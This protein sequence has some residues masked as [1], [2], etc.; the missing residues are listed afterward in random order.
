MN[1]LLSLIITLFVCNL[2]QGSLFQTD[3]SFVFDEMV[4]ENQT[5]AVFEARISGIVRSVT[6]GEPLQGATVYIQEL[7]RGVTTGDDGYFELLLPAGEYT[8]QVQYLGMETI[9]REIVVSAEEIRLEFEMEEQDMDLGEIIVEGV[10]FGDHIRGAVTGVEVVTISDLTPLP[11]FMGEIDV[12]QSLVAL[13]GVQTVG[14][15]A[16]GFNVRGG[17]EDQNLVLM[18]GAP[19]FNSSHVL[20]LFSVFNPDVTD[21]FALYKGHMPERFGGRL[22]SVLDVSMR[23]G[24]MQE[25]KVHGGLGLYSGRAMIEGPIIRNRLSFLMA[26]RGAASGII[27]QV[28]GKERD[29]MR[30]SLPQDVYNSSARFYDTNLNL[31]YRVNN[32]N[33]I[34]LSYYGSHDFFRFSD[35]FG[36]SWGNRIANLKWRSALSDHL[37]SDFSVVKNQ[38]N[39]SYFTPIGPDAFDLQTGIGYLRLQEELLYTGFQNLTINGGF[40]WTQ[41]SSNDESITPYHNQSVIATEK[42]PKD[43]GRELALY[44]GNELELG[45]H[46]LLLLGVRYSQFDHIGPGTLFE[47]DQNTSR[48]ASSITDSTLFASGDKMASYQ[49]FE[50]RISARISLSTNSSIKISY[51]RTRQ[52]IHQISN[53]VSPT[54][55]DIWQVS[56]SHLPP[57]KSHNY[58][59]GYFQNFK[60]G[61]WEISIDF[62]YRDVEDLVEYIDFAE[63]FL[64]PHIETDL[65]SARGKA[66]GSE[67]NI[68]KNSGKWTGWLSYTLGRTFVKADGL[69]AEESINRGEWFPSNYDQPHNV[70]LTGVRSLGENSAFSFNFTWRTGR[71]IT[72]I[73]SGYLDN[74]TT[75]PVFTDRNSERIPDYIRLDL[76]FL[77]ADNIWAYRTPDPNRRISDSAN[78]TFYNILGRKNA[79]SVFYQRKPGAAVPSPYRL[80]VLG[81][82]IPSFTYN[83]NF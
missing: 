48:T 76:S 39:S 53:S 25:F 63:L 67:I 57:Q 18:D 41:Y 24:S 78:I 27:F 56:T 6:S 34:S 59:I 1:L 9:T 81:A 8:L 54:P 50:P 64:N 68:R 13:P 73:R 15:G 75:V 62:Y 69:F 12:V 5:D 17:R 52:Y 36:Y 45:N 61:D 35:E 58:S 11:Q 83:L 42:V 77:I 33:R 32:D 2:D 37:F 26:G 60:D 70:N 31:S 23:S 21:G 28:A 71:P 30:I 82:V 38:Y 4:T 40:E 46:L 10:G 49:G 51:N 14:E 72:A 22:S 66:Y 16:S 47:Y 20:G 80:S 29:M 55:A 65:I 19:I 43:R 74:S 44:L 3:S 7:E 79:F